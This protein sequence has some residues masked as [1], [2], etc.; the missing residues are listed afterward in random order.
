MPVSENVSRFAPQS[1]GCGINHE[2]LLSTRGLG[3]G[4]HPSNEP[5]DGP[6][7]RALVC[8]DCPHYASTAQPTVRLPDS[9]DTSYW[10]LFG[11]L[12]KERKMRRRAQR[13]FVQASITAGI[14]AAIAL[15]GWAPRAFYLIAQSVGAH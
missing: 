5:V 14:L 13:A 12:D 2:K 6:R 1:T 10:L 9:S 4:G 11:A 15:A 3:P 8:P 7:E